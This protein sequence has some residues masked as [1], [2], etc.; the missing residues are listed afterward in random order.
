MKLVG[1]HWRNDCKVVANGIEGAFSIFIRRSEDFPENFSV[2]IVYEPKDG[3][4]EITLLRC[5]G[6]HGIFNGSF[7]PDHAHF[8]FH[9]HR[10]S[11]IAIANGFKPEKYAENTEEFAS[12]EEA[13]QYF[14]KLINLDAADAKRHFPD[15]TAQDMLPFEEGS[16]S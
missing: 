14:V 12:F 9:I 3:S 8:T 10:A 5:N 16:R 2:G 7:D 15:R 11:E 6:Q 13:V 4:G 1:A